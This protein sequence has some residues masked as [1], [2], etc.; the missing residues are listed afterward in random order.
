LLLSVS[1]ANAETVE[2]V[3]PYIGAPLFLDQAEG[4]EEDRAL[5]GEQLSEVLAKAHPDDLLEIVFLRSN[6][7]RIVYLRAAASIP[8]HPFLK[9]QASTHT[10]PITRMGLMANQGVL[11]TVSL[12]KTIMLWDCRTRQRLHTF[13]IPEGDGEENRPFS[14][15]ISPVNGDIVCGSWKASW[16][17]SNVLYVLD[18][19][20]GEISAIIRSLPN[21]AYHLAFSPNGRF[22]AASLG[23]GAGIRLFDAQNGYALLDTYQTD[24]SNSFWCDFSQDSS[25]LAVSSDT[26]AITVFDLSDGTLSVSSKRIESGRTPYTVAFSPDGR[27]LAVAFLD[28]LVSPIDVYDA[29]DLSLHYRP[30]MQGI[31]NRLTTLC[32]SSDGSFLFAG[33]APETHT[34]Q[35]FCWERGGRGAYSTISLPTDEITQLIPYNDGVLWSAYDGSWGIASTRAVL[36]SQTPAVLFNIRD[37]DPLQI[38]EKGERL[39]FSTPGCPYALVFDWSERV[40]YEETSETTPFPSLPPITTGLDI[41]DWKEGETPTIH[42]EVLPLQEGERSRVLSA[43]PSLNRFLIGT[44][45]YLREYDSE[46]RLR[47]RIQTPG[48][49]LSVRYTK[50]GAQCVA[51]YSDGT[52]RAYRSEDGEELCALWI[53]PIALEWITWTPAGYYACSESADQRIGWVVNRGTDRAPDFYPIERCYESFYRPD[54][55]SSCLIENRTDVE[56][57]YE[58][59]LDPDRIG[60]Y[61]PPPILTELSAQQKEEKE[62]TEESG[63]ETVP[64]VRLV[65]QC[66][67]G[68]ETEEVFLFVDG[69]R[70]IPTQFLREGSLRLLEAPIYSGERAIVLY[71]RREDGVYSN[72]C[73]VSIPKPIPE[74]K[75]PNLHIICL[76]VSDSETGGL[77]KFAHNDAESFIE[78]FV[79]QQPELYERVH[80]HYLK[81]SAVTSA[82]IND[83]LT[84]LLHEITEQDILLFYYSG[85]GLLDSETPAIPFSLIGLRG[86]RIPF[87]GLNQF[88]E[89][90][91]ARAVAIFIDACQS[92][93]LTDAYTRAILEG[94]FFDLH[95]KAG[96]SVFSSSYSAEAS[97]EVD[98]LQHGLFTFALLETI[99][100]SGESITL[101][102]LADNLR[103]LAP[104]IYKQYGH[105]SSYPKI[106][107]AGTDFPLIKRLHTE[108]GAKIDAFHRIE[109]TPGALPPG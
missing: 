60:F 109:Q 13:R 27:R 71:I 102:S 83:L 99:D 107:F 46:A 97:L 76:A 79:T 17:T 35:L 12:D 22:L 40:L 70:R 33:G 7:A 59:R 38:D 1:I 55:V 90:V 69:R 81:N 73:A 105:S 74:T 86:E 91:K 5:T 78:R 64:R 63:W 3:R 15:A 57:L 62:G 8:E 42:G 106:L 53:D 72:R 58:K 28:D 95:R 52:V 19:H 93:A 29:H 26:G 89:T 9:A 30:L 25:K 16:E 65:Y 11:A 51:A 98:Q 4:G 100:R 77:I 103:N 82:A 54:I 75:R 39:R 92:G 67:G 34:N 49:V 43:H 21:I 20:S 87:D 47:W 88:F 101:K 44:E 84:R 66:E 36:F 56:A 37:L 41:R 2:S 48:I 68:S 18:G 10:A 32:W 14:V 24:D 85:H 23:W 96:I 80:I 61:S 50:N 94:R 108:T 6:K 45:W 104:A 31:S